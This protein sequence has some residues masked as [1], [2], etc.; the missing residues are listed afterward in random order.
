MR[1]KVVSVCSLSLQVQR[2]LESVVT[3]ACHPSLVAF[4]PRRVQ[5]QYVLF[6]LLWESRALQDAYALD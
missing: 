2:R 4:Y 3:S 1:T 6:Y 5:V